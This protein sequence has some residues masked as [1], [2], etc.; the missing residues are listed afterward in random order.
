MHH[1]FN[2]LVFG[3]NNGSQIETN[4]LEYV[5]KADESLSSCDIINGR[6]RDVTSAR[7]K[8]MSKRSQHLLAGINDQIKRSHS[9]ADF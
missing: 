4:P 1:K 3:S 5:R 9:H 2:P 8:L 6:L 7:R